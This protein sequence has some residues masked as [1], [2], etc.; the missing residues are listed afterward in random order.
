MAEFYRIGHHHPDCQYHTGIVPGNGARHLTSLYTFIS[1]HFAFVYLLA[2]VSTLSLLIWLAA[3]KYGKIR[4]A[5]GDEQ[6]EFG[7]LSW[8]AMLFCAGVGAGLMYWAPIEWAYYIDAPPYGAKVGSVAAAE[9]ASSYGIFHW[10]PTAWAFYCLPTIAIAYP[11]YVKKLP[12]LRLS[13]SCHYFL[14]GKEDSAAARL[15][16]WLFMIGLLGGAGTSLGFST[17]MIAAAVG[18]ITGLETNFGLNLA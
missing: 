2:G 12:Q 6:P 5:A 13:T 9:W 17:P 10:G 7:G 8:A 3:S 11:Y 18:R 1:G 15:I 4:L 16:D 14:K